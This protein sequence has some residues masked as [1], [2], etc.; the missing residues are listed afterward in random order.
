MAGRPAGRGVATRPPP[1][2]S[3]TRMKSV[4][5][6]ETS[7]GTSMTPSWSSVQPAKPLDQRYYLLGERLEVGWVGAAAA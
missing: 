7:T 6:I 1:A 2:A 4:S 5:P 3:G